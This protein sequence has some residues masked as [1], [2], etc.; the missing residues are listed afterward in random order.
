MHD[1]GSPKR[2]RTGGVGILMAISGLGE[3]HQH[4]GSSADGEFTEASGTSSAYGQVGML[5]LPGNLIAEAAFNKL[6]VS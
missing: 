2:R 1:H 4:R 3:W 6:W 5:Q